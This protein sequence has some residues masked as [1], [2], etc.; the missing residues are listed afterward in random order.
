MSLLKKNITA[1]NILFLIFFKIYY[2]LTHFK[3]LTI[4]QYG[5]L[6]YVSYLIFLFHLLF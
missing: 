5:L 6:V 3:I 2:I 4:K 1:K